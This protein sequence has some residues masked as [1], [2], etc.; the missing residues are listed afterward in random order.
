MSVDITY[1]GATVGSERVADE[2]ERIEVAF[3]PERVERL[4]D[5]GLD[6][7]WD[8]ESLTLSMPAGQDKATD[9]L[10]GKLADT[11][12]VEL[13]RAFDWDVDDA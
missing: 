9:K 3:G 12:A 6:I 10:F 2:W 8:D 5:S 7:G 1:S 4:E 13:G 11:V